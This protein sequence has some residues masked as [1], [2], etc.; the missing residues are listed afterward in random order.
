[1]TVGGVIDSV[2]VK[3]Q[4]AGWLTERAD[5]L[6]DEQGTQAFQGL[7]GDTILETGQ[8]GLAGQVGAIGLAAKDEFEDRVTTQGVGVILVLVVS[9]NAEDALADHVHNRVID[10]L[11]ITR[12]VDGSGKVARQTKTFVELPEGEQASGTRE[13]GIAAFTDDGQ[14]GEKVDA[15]GQRSLYAHS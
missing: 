4:M 3:G 1:M 11:W 15:G 12:I 2:E 7:D 13:L 5:E 10:Q 14:S 6:I 9:E 8:S